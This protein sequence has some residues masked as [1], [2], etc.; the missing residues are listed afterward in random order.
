M[1]CFPLKGFNHMTNIGVLIYDLFMWSGIWRCSVFWE[2]PVYPSMVSK[3]LWR[4]TFGFNQ[5]LELVLRKLW[6]GFWFYIFCAFVACGSYSI[7]SGASFPL[8]NSFCFIENYFRLFQK[9]SFRQIWRYNV[10]V[11]NLFNFFLNSHILS[12]L[13]LDLY[14]FS[15]RLS[16]FLAAYA[17]CH[18]PCAITAN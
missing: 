12:V 16:P 14:C 18:A 9:H 6:K 1:D 17:L 15:L 2:Y 7:A 13:S 8:G 4:A 10:T 5:D 11:T 3:L